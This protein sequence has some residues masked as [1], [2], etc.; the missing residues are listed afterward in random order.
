MPERGNELE[1]VESGGRNGH[2]HS[3]TTFGVVVFWGGLPQVS[4]RATQRL[5]VVGRLHRPPQT[6]L[7]AAE[8]D[9]PDAVRT[10]FERRDTEGYKIKTLNLRIFAFNPKCNDRLNRTVKPFHY[11]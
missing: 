8:S 4:L 1:E 9:S 7:R 6:V 5:A 10:V 3:S 2:W 11:G